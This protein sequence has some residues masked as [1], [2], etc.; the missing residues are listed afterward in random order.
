MGTNQLL[1][2]MA[3]GPGGCAPA[4]D[5]LIPAKVRRRFSVMVCAVEQQCSRIEAY[6]KWRFTHP[7]SDVSKLKRGGEE[8]IKRPSYAAHSDASYPIQA[9][10]AGQGRR[11]TPPPE[12]RRGR[13]TCRQSCACAAPL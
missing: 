5:S 8:I 3:I 4:Q 1:D 9:A 10:R 7:L 11:P 13:P 6:D 12:C 2:D